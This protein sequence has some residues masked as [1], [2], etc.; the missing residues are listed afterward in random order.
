MTTTHTCREIINTKNL[1]RILKAKKTDHD[2][3]TE[4]KKMKRRLKNT[5]QH[6]IHFCL[7]KDG[8]QAGRLY[9]KRGAVSLQ[10]LKG[11]VRKALSH[12]TY[13]DVDMVN[14]HPTILSQ[15]FEREGLT[16]PHLGRY[17]AEREACLAET[18]MTRKDAKTA[19][20]LLMYG[21]KPRENATP[22]MTDFHTE[23]MLN[24]AAV[25]DLVRATAPA[26]PPATPTTTTTAAIT[27]DVSPD[28]VDEH[29]S[30]PSE[31]EVHIFPL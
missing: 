23:L 13:T 3:L 8:E 16:C 31:P 4:L 24:A 14:A 2:T 7:S 17:V 20:I 21:G 18:G 6:K 22:F 28:D 30:V 26:T 19:F 1:N 27:T 10:N 9:P 15:L 12:D 11:D 5:N 29:E 25:L